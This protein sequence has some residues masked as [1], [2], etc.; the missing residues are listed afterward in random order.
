MLNWFQWI[1]LVWLFG[2]I[3]PI[4]LRIIWRWYKGF[5]W[6]FV[7][8]LLFSFVFMFLFVSGFCER[9]H[10]CH[11]SKAAATM[12]R[13]LESNCSVFEAF[14]GPVPIAATELLPSSTVFIVQEKPFIVSIPDSEGVFRGF[15]TQDQY[16]DARCLSCPNKFCQHTL[17]YRN[18]FSLQPTDVPQD[19]GADIEADFEAHFNGH[20][21][22][23]FI[24]PKQR[25]KRWPDLLVNSGRFDKPF[26]DCIKRFIPP[27]NHRWVKF[28]KFVSFSFRLT[29]SFIGKHCGCGHAWTDAQIQESSQVFLINMSDSTN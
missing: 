25:F 7:F 19:D 13:F 15:V 29:P 28:Q 23:P 3:G 24:H 4:A 1:L 5:R 17:F 6:L 16:G 18:L 2:W 9:Y 11:H 10:V 12:F 21:N 22:S 14:N 20:E 27:N 8:F 26:P